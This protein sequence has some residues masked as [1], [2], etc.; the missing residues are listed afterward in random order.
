MVPDERHFVGNTGFER[1]A[2][3]R[4]IAAV[5]NGNYHI[6]RQRKFTR[7]LAPHLNANFVDVAIGN[8]AVRTG[9]IDVLKDA[10]RAALVLGKS[11][12][13]GQAILVDRHDFAGLDITNELRMNEIKRA[14]FAGEDITIANPA[15]A[16]G[17]KAMRIPD[18]DELILS[19][20]DQG[21][22]PFDAPNALDEIVMVTI[23]A[24]LS[25]QV[26]DDLTIHRGLK[27]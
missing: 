16:Q 11:L 10:E 27:N 3:G 8:V 26:E 14:G 24:G 17:T 23:E 1:V 21:I 20:N 12:D 6:G 9:E 18:P 25:H 19:H 4:A 2:Q 13:T 15:Q 22:S 7:Q 5:R